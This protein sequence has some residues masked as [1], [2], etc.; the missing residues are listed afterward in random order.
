MSFSN[1][2][3]T[4]PGG[5]NRAK[6]DAKSN[7]NTAIHDANTGTAAK[8]NGFGQLSA[9]VTGSVNA[10]PAA[11]SQLFR[12]PQTLTC[13]GG[14]CAKVVDSNLAYPQGGGGTKAEVVTQVSVALHGALGATWRPYRDSACSDLVASL[15]VT[16]QPGDTANYTNLTYQPPSGVAVPAGQGLYAYTWTADVFL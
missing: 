9:A 10:S 4:D 1:V 6:V 15:F 12:T 11:P 14:H 2:A 13:G 8:V 5:V 7:L 16:A 3:I